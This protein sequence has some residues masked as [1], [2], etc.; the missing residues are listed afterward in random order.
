VHESVL[1]I[2]INR[3]EQSRGGG[4]ARKTSTH[5]STVL[6]SSERLTFIL[7]KAEN[8]SEICKTF[9]RNFLSWPHRSRSAERDDQR[10]VFYSSLLEPFLDR[11]GIG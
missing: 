5:N 4:H 8:E 9:G 2:K 1:T 7:T 10:E 3:W 11:I 6:K